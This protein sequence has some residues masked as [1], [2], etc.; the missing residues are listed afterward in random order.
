MIKI[1]CAVIAT[2]GLYSVL[3]KESKL[4]RFFEHIFLGLAAGYT[5][6]ATW[7]DT[8]FS[9]WWIKM[10][11]LPAENGGQPQMGYWI[12]AALL[13]IGLMGYLVFSKKHNWMS[14]I[15]LGVIL[16][17][18]S[19][20]QVSIWWNTWGPQLYSSMHP[21]IPTTFSRMTVPS[22]LEVVNGELVTIADPAQLT[23]VQQQ[24]AN[25]LYPSQALTN[26]I[27]IITLISAFSYFLF[28]F[29]LKG[30]FLTGLN[31]TGRWMLMV[32]FGAIFGSTVMARFALVIDRMS[33]V[34]NEWFQALLRGGG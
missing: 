32:G 2:I 30:K 29:D 10:L 15:P 28:S 24:I 9:E 20:Q 6:V 14:K 26:L 31:T 12:Y 25:N 23:E 5:L 7:K 19:G 11:G 16:G 27:F 18:W 22:T 21:V 3:Y 13:P 4:Y 17:L 33:Y 34:W 8:L 1:T